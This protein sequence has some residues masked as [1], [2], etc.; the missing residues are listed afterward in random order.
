MK[1]PVRLG[2]PYNKDIN[3]AKMPFFIIFHAINITE[4]YVSD[5]SGIIGLG[6]PSYK[7][8]SLK[9]NTLLHNLRASGSI[10]KEIVSYNITFR[11]DEW[12]SEKDS[13]I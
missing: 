4:T 12:E 2:S 5:Q 3:I 9:E 11:P 1:E 6:M 13:Y 8:D 10:P 7:N